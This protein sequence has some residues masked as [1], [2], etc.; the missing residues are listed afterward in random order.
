MQEPLPHLPR[1][2]LTLIS[3]PVSHRFIALLAGFAIGETFNDVYTSHYG[4]KRAIR[5]LSHIDAKDIWQPDSAK[6]GSSDYNPRAEFTIDD[7]WS[8]MTG[9]QGPPHAQ[10]GSFIQ[11]CQGISPISTGKVGMRKPWESLRGR[12]ASSECHFQAL[13]PDWQ[14][15]DAGRA[16]LRCEVNGEVLAF[17]DTNVNAT[18]PNRVSPLD[19]LMYIRDNGTLARAA[20]MPLAMRQSA[21]ATS[22]PS[23]AD[24]DEARAHRHAQVKAAY[25][26]VRREDPTA[27]SGSSEPPPSPKSGLRLKSEKHASSAMTSSP[28]YHTPSSS[29]IRTPVPGASPNAHH[30]QSIV[31]RSPQPALGKTPSRPLQA[32]TQTA[33]ALA[34][35]SEAGLLEILGLTVTEDDRHRTDQR[36]YKFFST[37]PTT[38]KNA[39]QCE[40]C[41]ASAHSRCKFG[42]CALDCREV[43]ALGTNLCGEHKKDFVPGTHDLVI[44][45]YYANTDQ[46]REATVARA[47]RGRVELFKLMPA[48]K[49]A[50]DL[51]NLRGHTVY[52]F[53]PHLDGDNNMRHWIKRDAREA[54]PVPNGVELVLL[55]DST[56]LP[57]TIPA[58]P[59]PA[60]PP[61]RAAIRTPVKQ[62]QRSSP[63]RPL[64]REDDVTELSSSD[65]DAPVTLGKR[66]QAPNAARVG[67]FKKRHVDVIDLTSD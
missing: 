9:I 4:R 66:R 7:A 60:L 26:A 44:R 57:A 1:R 41:E 40:V 10:P 28:S 52:Q 55:A 17:L 32:P 11:D 53:R 20:Q 5:C 56:A 48:L 12:S 36:K 38:K 67:P 54:I 34:E 33:Q 22:S 14:A 49:R 43:G 51:G 16:P 46:T 19:R 62:E 24:L 65:D 29:R 27:F 35:A 39:V 8:A 23:R 64:T 18:H 30:R 15:E 50:L 37:H 25:D 47:S 6:I 61:S 45:I 58:V 59:R 63:Q 31:K 42:M 21:P 13:N 2:R 3:A